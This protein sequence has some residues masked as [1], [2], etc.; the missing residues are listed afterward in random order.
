MA[1]I[2]KKQIA[3]YN[4]K[5][6]HIVPEYNR[7]KPEN[8]DGKITI[9][10][11]SVTSGTYAKYSGNEQTEGMYIQAHTINDGN[12]RTGEW[13]DYK[14]N[15]LVAQDDLNYRFLLPTG[16]D[17]TSPTYNALLASCVNSSNTARTINRI[18]SSF[19]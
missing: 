16:E 12:Y 5:V 4:N 9:T 7:H 17:N 10:K 18:I 8:I 2:G 1:N 19:H 3:T 15:Q 11:T 13:T 14:E 6:V